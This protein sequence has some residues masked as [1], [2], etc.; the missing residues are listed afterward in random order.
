MLGFD[1]VV[2]S[3]DG[4]RLLRQHIHQ[5]SSGSLCSLPA[6][7]SD[8]GDRPTGPGR[9]DGDLRYSVLMLG[10]ERERLSGVK[11]ADSRKEGCIEMIPAVL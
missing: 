11:S 8:S 6:V 7:L 10:D 5:R 3:E 4:L 1:V 9:R 2:T